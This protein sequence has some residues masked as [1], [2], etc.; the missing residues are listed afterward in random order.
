MEPKT[1]ISVA[2]AVFIVGGLVF[3]HIR[4]TKRK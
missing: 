2:L 4:A 1:I 3:L